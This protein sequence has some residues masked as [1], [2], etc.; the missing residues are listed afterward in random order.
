MTED[1]LQ[2]VLGDLTNERGGVVESVEDQQEVKRVSAIFPVAS[3]SVSRSYGNC[4]N[5]IYSTC[6]LYLF[7]PKCQQYNYVLC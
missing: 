5:S 7:E 3:L 6:I 4:N 2:T 1:H